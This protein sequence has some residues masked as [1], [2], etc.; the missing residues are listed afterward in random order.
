MRGREGIHKEHV[1]PVWAFVYFGG[2]AFV[3]AAGTGLVLGRSPTRR[4]VAAGS[5]VLLIVGLVVLNVLV[6]DP[7]TCHD[8]TPFLSGAYHALDIFIAFVNVTAWCVGLVFGIQLGEL[9]R[10][11]R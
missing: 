9:R 7:D 11:F 10:R 6:T 8:C 1:P 4:L 2:L 5:G 3:V